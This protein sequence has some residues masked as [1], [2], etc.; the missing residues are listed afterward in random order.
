MTQTPPPSSSRPVDAPPAPVI[1]FPEHLP[2]AERREEIMAAVAEHQVVVVAG[3]TGS[4]KTTQLPKMLLALGLGEHGVVGH[5]QPRR[6]AARTVA[7]RIAEELGEDIGGTVGYQ[8][9]FTAQTSRDTRVKV[10]TDGILLAEIPH[11]PLLRRYSA[12]IVDEAHERSLNIDFL[13]GYLKRLLPQRPDL[14]VIITSATIDPERFARHF[15]R[16]LTEGEEHEDAVEADDGAR[17]IPAPVIEVSGRT[18]PVEIRYRPLTDEPSP[19]DPED[20]S[21]DRAE[22]RDPIDAVG[23]AVLEL[24]GEA[25]GDILVFFPGEREI[26]EAADHLTGVVAGTPRLAGTEVLPLYGRLSMAEQHRVFGRAGAG[27]R[28]RIVLA[29]NVAETSL[30]VPGIKYVIDTGTARISRYSHRTKVQR[31]PIERISQASANQR[32]GRSGR[33]SPGIAIRLYSEEDFL[34][35]PEFTDPEILRTSLASVIL[36]M[37]SLGVADTPRQVQDF[38]FVQPPDSRQVSDGAAT[39]TELGALHAGQTRTGGRGRAKGSGG[40][41]AGTITPIGR[42]LA[43]LPVDPRLGRMILEAGERGCTREVMVLAAALTVQD[44]RERPTE[45]RAAADEMHARFSDENSDF[46][47]FLN[48]WAYLREQRRELSG[49]QFRKL[50]RREHINWLR[51]HEWQDLVQQLQQMA[52]EVGVVVPAG[53]VDPVG[54][55]EAV[56]RSLLTGLLS[57][58]G[59]Y[60]ERRREYAGAR[61]TRFA[62]FPGSALFKKRHPLV[63]AAELVETSRLWARTVARVE[64]E[65]VEEAAG[66]L[67]TRSYS[68]PHWSRRAGSVVAMEKVTLFGVTLVPERSVRYWR[69]DPELSRELFIRHA[70]VEG[71]WRTR[72]RFFA[73]NRRALEEVEELETRLRR[74]DLRI[75]DEDLFAF[76]DARIPAN[77]VSERH[78]DSWWKKARHETPDLLDLDLEALLTEDAE[79]LDTDAFPTVFHYPL[80]GGDVDLDLEYTYDP[81]GASGT[82]GVT[83]AVPV[84]LL[85]EVA[86]GPFAWLVP[87]LRQELVTALIKTLPKA[88]RRQLVPAPDVARLLVADLD[89]HA[90]PLRDDL[91]AALSAAARRVRG[92]V[93]EPEL[94]RTDAVP[95]HLRMDYRVVDA[96]GAVMGAGQ[97]L[98][99]LQ[100]R[101][102]QANRSAIAARLAGTDDPSS[103]R[104]GPSRGGRRGRGGAGRDGGAGRGGDAGRDGQ[105]RPARPTAGGPAAGAGTGFREQ[106]GLTAWTIGTV[107]RRITTEAGA[108]GPAI[109]GFPALVPETPADGA[110]AAGLVVAR[111]AEDQAA[112]HRAGVIAL[113]LAT[114]PSTHR[115]VMDHLDNREKL[116]F[117]QNPHGSVD[118]LV[119]DST[120][121]AVDRLVG[122]DLPFDEAAFSA[123]YDRVR[124]DLIDTVFAVTSLVAQ[125]LA[126][127]AQVRR[128][129]KG[130]VS[131]A[132]AP[133]MSDV[134]AHLEQLVFD[135]FVAAAGWERL[136]H[137]PRYVTGMTA[138]LDKLDA[139][140]HLQR[141][142]QAMAVVQRLEDEFDAAVAAHRTRFPGTPIPADLEQVRWLLEE[143]RVSLF[144]Q[145]LGTAVSVSEKRVRQAL[146][147]AAA[148]R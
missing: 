63:M 39:L 126:G 131:L 115:Y 99:V 139:G 145:E 46:T 80:P 91:P 110:P 30:T 146:Q 71:D 43:R 143:L 112:W 31:L 9:R 18:Y 1:T 13:L 118:S 95:D 111:S 124:A 135:G 84:L 41:A 8:V 24:A 75:G 26:R 34:S 23:E 102:A 125:V 147:R 62:V 82:D 85:H 87:G 123:L 114:L 117:T 4:G 58:V 28:R 7:E 21:D 129:L 49:S 119:R 105:S 93:V 77:V 25:P 78:F 97:D 94:W 10:M 132:T 33:T 14:K 6:L 88:V 74:R 69:I 134:K 2:V 116:T 36:Q 113:L 52:K 22:T 96:R 90:D 15:G 59:A 64:P 57:H 47:A 130:T 20:D 107:P 128:R 98:P 76:Y 67:V 122:T 144:A 42:R 108:R 40:A 89:E 60:D 65:W 73:R 3:E 5:T 37:L 66:D 45:Q 141:D 16:P 136:Q 48:L 44:P 53:P 12:I 50:C 83:V 68:E 142:G 79:Q 148:A 54:R 104:P 38:P 137:L 32:S 133:A 27:V 61:G 55:H 19:D 17:V 56:H 100:A 29:T 138:R 86:P 120:H 127:A 109:T 11:D 140:G 51:V 72:H 101:L 81:T 35:R 70:L 103:A 92:V 106:H 121:A